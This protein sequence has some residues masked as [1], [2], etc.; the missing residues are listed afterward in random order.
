MVTT[1]NPTDR[2]VAPETAKHYWVVSITDY[3]APLYAELDAGIDLTSEVST[4]EGFEVAADNVAVP[5]GGTLFTGQI[6]GRINPGDASIA[7]Y[8]SRD[9]DDVRTVIERKDSGFVVV[10]HG[11]NIAGQLMD[12]FPVRVRSVSKPIDYPAS[13]A[14]MVTVQFSI[15][16]EPAENVTIPAAP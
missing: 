13:N 10:F 11:G 1:L 7:F 16:R 14:T 8:A 2:Y 3:T 4:A 9:T 5:D 6:P 15:T 12:I